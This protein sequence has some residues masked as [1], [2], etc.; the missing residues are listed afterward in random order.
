MRK[1]RV[2]VFAVLAGI[3]FAAVLRAGI[4]SMKRYLKMEKM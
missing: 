3:V 2:F 4:P 1:R